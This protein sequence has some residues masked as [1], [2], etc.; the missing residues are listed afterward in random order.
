MEQTAQQ[1]E[2]RAPRVG[3]IAG[4]VSLV[5]G[6][7]AAGLAGVHHCPWGGAG[8]RRVRATQ[9]RAQVCVSPAAKKQPS[10]LLRLV[11]RLPGAGRAVIPSPS[12]SGPARDIAI[13][14]SASATPDATGTFPA[15]GRL[16][17]EALDH[18]RCLWTLDVGNKINRLP[19]VRNMQDYSAVYERRVHAVERPLAHD[20]GVR[21]PAVGP[22]VRWP[23]GG[24]R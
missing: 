14:P 13:S 18:G 22:E 6:C 2:Q 12:D 17:L 7:A 5:H 9:L 11:S 20:L 24:R 21:S 8:R 4:R 23:E 15:G 16:F 10:C 19:Q 1:L 3:L